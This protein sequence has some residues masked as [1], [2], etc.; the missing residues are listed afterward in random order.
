MQGWAQIAVVKQKGVGD[1]DAGNFVVQTMNIDN[2]G[3][4]GAE[5][6]AVKELK[7]TDNMLGPVKNKGAA[8]VK[9]NNKVEI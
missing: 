7:V 3:V 2:A 8:P 1:L 6:N 5:V 4:G 9:K